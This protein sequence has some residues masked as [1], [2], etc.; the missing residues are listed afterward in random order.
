[1]T[2]KVI[3]NNYD[4]L[5]IKEKLMEYCELND[6]D[7]RTIHHSRI[8]N[9]V[10]NN[11]YCA[12]ELSENEKFLFTFLY[13]LKA[14]QR[15]LPWVNI[16]Q[17]KL[18]FILWKSKGTI[19][20]DINTLIRYNLIIKAKDRFNETVLIPNENINTWWVAIGTERLS[21]LEEKR[22]HTASSHKQLESEYK[23]YSNTKQ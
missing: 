23:S 18:A 8:K 12:D 9:Y 19:S 10:M 4:N 3:E 17:E 16:N 1:M 2:N 21:F 20:R 5:H 15:Y 14:Q 7:I 11:L 13:D 22:K 6:I